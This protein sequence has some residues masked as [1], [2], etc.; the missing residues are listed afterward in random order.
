[1]KKNRKEEERKDQMIGEALLRRFV[2]IVIWL[3]I[4]SSK[5]AQIVA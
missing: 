5:E 1:M 3:P 2:K 4:I